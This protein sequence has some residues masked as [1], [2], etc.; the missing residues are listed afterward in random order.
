MEKQDQ[1]VKLGPVWLLWCGAQRRLLPAGL[2]AK[3]VRIGEYSERTI[4]CSYLPALVVHMNTCARGKS[5]TN[6][7]LAHK[8]LSLL[9]MEARQNWYYV[10]Y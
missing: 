5:F 6:P 1:W 8:E 4:E 9:L 3:M 2:K 7:T 10:L